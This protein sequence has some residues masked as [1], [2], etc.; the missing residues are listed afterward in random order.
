MSVIFNQTGARNVKTCN[1]RCY[2]SVIFNQRGARNVKT[3][4]TCWTS[5][6]PTLWSV[7]LLSTARNSP[8]D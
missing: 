5:A 2:M 3:C 6:S 7:S 1:T 8:C 4:N